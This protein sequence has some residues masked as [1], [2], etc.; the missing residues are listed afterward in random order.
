VEYKGVTQGREAVKNLSK[1]FPVIY[2][3]PLRAVK[4]VNR[5]IYRETLAHGET[6]YTDFLLSNHFYVEN[7]VTQS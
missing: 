3:S 4:K 5:L 6:F 7:F 2:G 1:W